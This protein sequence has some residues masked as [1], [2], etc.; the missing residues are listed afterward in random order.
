MRTERREM[1][2]QILKEEYGI[3]ASGTHFIFQ[4]SFMERYREREKEGGRER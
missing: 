4:N 3:K 2:F 1:I